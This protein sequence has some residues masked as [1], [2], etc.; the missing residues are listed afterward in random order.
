M[1]NILV[2][3]IGVI[4]IPG[5]GPNYVEPYDANKTIGDI[6]HNLK[7][8]GFGESNKTIQIFKYEKNDL[9]KYN[10]DDPYWSHD[11]KILD[12]VNIVGSFGND[13]MLIYVIV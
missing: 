1:K 12:Y 2:Y 6:I 13:V 4:G 11:T 3:W 10:K 9:N 5:K 7:K 8:Y